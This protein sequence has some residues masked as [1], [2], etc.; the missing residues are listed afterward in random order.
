MVPV[1]T[2]ARLVC[3]TFSVK[4]SSSFVGMLYMLEHKMLSDRFLRPA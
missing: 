3:E 4:T 1:L 2:G